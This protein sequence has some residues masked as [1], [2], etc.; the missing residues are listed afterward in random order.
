VRE[1]AERVL[2]RAGKSAD[3]TSDSS[4]LRSIDVPILVGDNRKLRA[5]T[6]WSPTRSIDDIIDDLIHAAP[7]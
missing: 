4:L 7:R 1:L 6:G 5:T 2:K 3:I